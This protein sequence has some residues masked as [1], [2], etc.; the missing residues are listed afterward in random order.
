MNITKAMTSPF[1]AGS[2]HFSAMV[3]NMFKNIDERTPRKPLTMG[4]HVIKPM[5][6]VTVQ[7]KVNMEFKSVGI[8]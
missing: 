2:G 3:K 1:T 7:H 4:A 5:S 8:P 6:E